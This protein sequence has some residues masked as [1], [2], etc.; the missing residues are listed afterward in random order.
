MSSD[1]IEHVQLEK[2]FEAPIKQKYRMEYTLKL[3]D[4]LYIEQTR[5]MNI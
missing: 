3:P 1:I 5:K 4:S 2:L